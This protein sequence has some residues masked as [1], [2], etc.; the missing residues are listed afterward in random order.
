MS[1]VI[2]DV[3]IVTLTWAL[4]SK[5]HLKIVF[6]FKENEELIMMINYNPNLNPLLHNFEIQFVLS[7]YLTIM[8]KSRC[9]LT[10]LDFLKRKEFKRELIL[11]L[12]S[13]SAV[14]HHCMISIVLFH[15]IL[16]KCLDEFE[17]K[18]KS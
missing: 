15:F 1:K 10:Y 11:P 5:S 7:M 6:K 12:I 16:F 9:L 14:V 17:K 13:S 3:C 2:H 8:K 4:P 18:I